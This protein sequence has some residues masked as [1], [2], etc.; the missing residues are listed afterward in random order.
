MR[1]ITAQRHARSVDGLDGG[2]GVALDAGDLHQAA[3][4]VAGQAQVVFHADLGG[5]L[6]L[7]G[8]AAHHRA[9]RTGGHAA[10]HA[11]FALAADFGTADA[12]VFLVE[13][14]DGAG[15]EQEVDHAR[16][17]RAR[18]EARVVVQH[19]RHD[20]CCAIRGCGHHAPAGGVF[21]VDGQ[22]IEVDPI[23]HLQRVA[24]RLFGMGR[25]RIAQGLG[26]AAHL[27][28]AGQGAVRAA[29]AHHAGLHHL[30]DGQQAGIDLGIG[31]PV[32]LVVAHHTGDAAA[33]F[34]SALQQFGAAVK[35]MGQD[36]GVGC[37]DGVAAAVGGGFVADHEPAAHRVVD[38]A[39]H[40][41]CGR[42]PGREAHAVGVQ[43]QAFAAV[44]VQ[45]GLFV[46]GDLV[47]ATQVD[48]PRA[49]HAVQQVGDRVHVHTVGLV[50][51]QA[52]QHGLVAAVALAGGAERAV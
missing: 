41:G 9:Q 43:R 31:A 25:E 34:A 27:E 12:G 8:C 30:P 21:F 10:G 17:R 46:E 36:R 3:H 16:I 33:Q 1:A 6:G 20:A 29:A 48:A 51:G 26:A 5:V 4:G 22:G 45:I 39:L 24:Q 11:H 19:G 52:Q 44:Q 13:Q 18:H 28:A 23:Q 42:V 14:A 32:P 35:G 50:A 38:A 37:D 15:G 2:D 7:F 49:A 40:K 47:L